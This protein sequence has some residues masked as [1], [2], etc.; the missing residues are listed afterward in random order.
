MGF[1][2][3]AWEALLATQRPPPV[4]ARMTKEEV[5][6]VARTALADRGGVHPQEQ[7]Y[8]DPHS[9]KGRVTWNVIVRLPQAAFGGH[10]HLIID[11]ATGAVLQRFDVPH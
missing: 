9:S 2:R 1:F 4:H 11:D 5:E 3:R 8:S 7:A 10:V 6:T